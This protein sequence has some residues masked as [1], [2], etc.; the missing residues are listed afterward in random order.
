MTV[1]PEEGILQSYLDGE[2]GVDMAVR[3]AGHLAECTAC[4]E[5]LHALE[6][7]AGIA[8]A[9]LEPYRMETAAMGLPVRVP[10]MR[11]LPRRYQSL[12]K[13]RR[14]INM[15]HRYKWLTGAAAAVLVLAFFLS[16]APARSLAAQFLNI[17]RMEKIQVVE[18][19][20]KDMAQLDKLFDGIE[21]NEGPTGEVD[22][23]NFGKVK[24]DYPVDFTLIV[25][26]SQVESLS[27]LN[28]YLPT[29]L[30]GWNRT[31]ISIEQPPIITFTPDV[32]SLNNYLRKHSDQLLPPALAGQSII[33][34]IPPIV[35]A[36]YGFGQ[37][38]EGF[39]IFAARDL[40][41]EAPQG[42]NLVYLRSALLRLPFLPDNF[43]RQLADI[44]DWRHTLPVPETQN[45][46]ATEI[47]V[48]G[49]QGVYFVDEFDVST[50]ILAWRQGDSWRA[51]SGLPLEEALSVAAEGEEWLLLK[52]A[53]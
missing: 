23:R 4:R 42:I 32:E 6:E 36:Q 40:V 16:W 20:P 34:N 15:I 35:R 41:I 39:V 13:T 44:E 30:A 50:V 9:A 8:T 25:E 33:I 1:C 24:F 31:E 2:L 47:L 52:F 37:D 27:G 45:M 53:L 29:T 18:I 11:H 51:I 14:L 28:L 48:N 10:R 46:G 5:R 38:G 21:G 26:P 22:I 7:L 19:T 49:N 3:V 12:T 43:R 17:F